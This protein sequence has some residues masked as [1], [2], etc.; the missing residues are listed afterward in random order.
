MRVLPGVDDVIGVS[1]ERHDSSELND[2]VVCK[3]NSSESLV[4]HFKNGA[5]GMFAM[6]MV[7]SFSHLTCTE[8]WAISLPRL[9]P[10]IFSLFALL[11]FFFL[12]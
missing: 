10:V 12:F 3:K 8:Q 6:P 11:P 7:Q 1:I 2:T 4:G 5:S 9:M